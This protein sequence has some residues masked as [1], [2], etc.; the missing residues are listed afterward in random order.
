MAH[1]LEHMAFK[2]T[3]TVGTTDFRKEAPLLDQMDEGG[4]I[5][6]HLCAYLRF[7]LQCHACGVPGS[8]AR[9]LRLHVLHGGMVEDGKRVGEVGEWMFGICLGIPAG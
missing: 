1:L 7:R 6:R 4:D 5:P 3:P 2:G 9:S 8:W